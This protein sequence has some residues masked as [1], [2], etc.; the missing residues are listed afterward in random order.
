[1]DDIPSEVLAGKVFPALCSEKFILYFDHSGEMCIQRMP[2]SHA[3]LARA[4]TD[5]E[6]IGLEDLVISGI[7]HACM[8]ALDR[9]AMCRKTVIA[10]RKVET[11]RSVGKMPGE[12]AP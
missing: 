6:N 10:R 1:M 7:G 2:D 12:S 5:S 8:T 4:I 3:G 11:S 9:R